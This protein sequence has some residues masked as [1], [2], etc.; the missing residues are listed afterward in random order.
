MLLAGAERSM[1]KARQ[2]M[3]KKGMTMILLLKYKNV[4]HSSLSYLYHIIYLLL[5][6]CN[7]LI[8]C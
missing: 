3:V 1:F 8:K 4:Y 2:T 6:Q 5:N 7:D